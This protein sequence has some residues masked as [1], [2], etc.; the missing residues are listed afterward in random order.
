M[1]TGEREGEK[2][3][4]EGQI[5]HMA[6]SAA[7]EGSI[8]ALLLL[9]VLGACGD[10]AALR[11]P[12]PPPRLARP[13]PL[14]PRALALRGGMPLPHYVP[15]RDEAV[16]RE[17][18]EYDEMM[19]EHYLDVERRADEIKAEYPTA[20]L[21]MATNG[22]LLENQPLCVTREDFARHGIDPTV[23]QIL[24]LGGANHS[25]VRIMAGQEV[26]DMVRREAPL[27]P[28]RPPLNLSDPEV[29]IH[30]QMLCIRIHTFICS[31]Y[32][33]VC[34][35]VCVTCTYVCMYV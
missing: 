10:G 15:A 12:R 9:L 34:L 18:R 20:A 3:T 5:V 2:I 28:G 13:P 24:P 26:T 31:I 16:E 32:V 1:R 17:E 27:F 35:C 8:G 23:P 19:A 21:S 14:W 11:G 29:R 33:C 4:R 7:R 6:C 25:R 22:S 30:L